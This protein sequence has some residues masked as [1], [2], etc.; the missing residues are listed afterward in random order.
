M[1]VLVAA[2]AIVDEVLAALVIAV[3]YTSAFNPRLVAA[4][5]AVAVSF[6]KNRLKKYRLAMPAEKFSDRPLGPTN[7]QT[8]S[9]SDIYE[10]TPFAI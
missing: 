2:P 5:F 9:H 8:P 4:S 1:K 3:F 6:V 10:C 7:Q